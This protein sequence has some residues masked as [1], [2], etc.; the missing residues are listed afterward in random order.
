MESCLCR[1]IKAVI[2]EFVIGKDIRRI[3]QGYH[4]FFVR[5]TQNE[6][7]HKA[8]ERLMEIDSVKEV[9]ITEGEYGFV[10]KAHE[11]GDEQQVIGR[12][13]KAVGGSTVKVVCHCRYVRGH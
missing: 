8:V 12:I 1:R 7:V 5:P 2:G 4:Y 11:S 9:S 6:D 3:S 13:N 10:V